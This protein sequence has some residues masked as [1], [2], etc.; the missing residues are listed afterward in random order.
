MKELKVVLIGA[1]SASF[2]RGTIADLMASE[3][4]REFDLTV[5]L[6]D[7]D[8]AALNRMHKLAQLLKEHYR[9]KAKI[10][11]TT[12]RKEALPGANYVIVSVARNR[13]Q[14]WEKD[15]YIPAVYGFRHVNGEN[16]GPGSAFHTLRSLHLMIPIAED[17]EKLCPDALLINFTNPESRVCLGINKLTSIT[18]VGLCHG[19]F[20]TLEVISRVLGRP[21]E[22]IDL[23][24]GGINHFHWALQIR[25]RSDGKDL[26]PE[27]DQ[28]MKQSDWGLDPFIRRMY[29]L[30]GYLTYP[31]PSH[32]GEYVSFAHEIAGPVIIKWG[33]GEVSRRLGAKASDRS[34][35]VE[36]KPNQP[37]YELWSME[38]ADKIQQ[39]VEGKEPITGR[40]TVIAAT[41]GKEPI[42]EEFTKPTRELAI[43]II[44]DIEFNRNKKELSVN[45]PNKN[46]AISNLPEDAIVEIPGRVNSEGIHPVKVGALPEAIAALCNIQISIQNLLI[47]AYRQKSKRLLLQALIID[48]I[49]D[50]VDRAEQ[51][52]E[53]MLKIEADYLPELH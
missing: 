50:S 17:M 45:I 4:L 1:G 23:T 9:S 16:G 25:S 7:I 19:A 30:F 36:G 35:I 28:K 21:E 15:F 40:F 53:H 43:P 18:S 38:Q 52:M 39:I 44:C 27:F 49:V 29:E 10:E 41:A 37:S 42:T 3:E 47:E 51:M 8:N 31:A 32:P 46:F 12:D 6:V 22:D 11:A 26:H 34:Y 13:W 5:E 20:E 2:G 33:I 14:L 48:P 24:I